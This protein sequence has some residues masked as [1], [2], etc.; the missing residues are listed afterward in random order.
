MTNYFHLLLSSSLTNGPSL[1]MKFLGQR[2]V[3]YVNRTYRRIGSLWEGAFI[4][5]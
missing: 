2:Y 4:R 3:Q 5:A 1:L